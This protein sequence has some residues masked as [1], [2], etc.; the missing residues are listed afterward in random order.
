VAAGQ[1]VGAIAEH[2]PH[3]RVDNLVKAAEVALAEAGLPP[4]LPDGGGPGTSEGAQDSGLM[5]FSR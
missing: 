2:V 1:A 3:V 4:Q 5:Q